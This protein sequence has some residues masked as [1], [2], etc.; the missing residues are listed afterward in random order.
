MRF[1]LIGLTA[2]CLFAVNA[3]AEKPTFKFSAFGTL[4]VAHST[5]DKADYTGTQ[6]QPDGVGYT[7]DY[8][9]GTDSKVG[10]QIDVGFMPQLSFAAQALVEQEHKGDYEIGVALAFLKWAPG[11]GVSIRGGRLP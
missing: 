2:A 1:K 8:D 9:F 10:G 5:E 3:S 4:S 6:Y 7:R 11:A